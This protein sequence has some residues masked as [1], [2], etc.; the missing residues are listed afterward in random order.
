MNGKIDH[1]TQKLSVFR[2]A[3]SALKETVLANLVLIGEIPAPSCDE[4][5]RI[6][7]MMDRFVEDGLENISHDEMGNGVAIIPGTERKSR[8]LLVSNADTIFQDKEDHTVQVSSSHVQGIGLAEN[9]LGLAVMAS[10][11]AILESLGLTF[12]SDVVLLCSVRSH[13]KSNLE[14][15]RFFL[16]NNQLPITSGICLDG[17]SLGRLG[18]HSLGLLRGEITC[19]VPEEYDWTRFG[20]TGAIMALNDVI[21]K[22]SAICMPTRPRTSIM[23]STMSGG[24]SYRKVPTHSCLTFDVY[25]ESDRLVSKLERQINEIVEEVSAGTRSTMDF[26]IISRCHPGGLAFGHPM[27][28]CAREMIRTLGEEPRVLPSST[29]LAVFVENNIPAVNLGLTTGEN[30]NEL[31]EKLAIEPISSGI[32]QLLGMLL[33]IDGGFCNER[34]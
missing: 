15:F 16:K 30:I 3:A 11:P 9:T 34:E 2:E 28:C 19:S 1:I 7:F 29:E 8:I 5:K 17:V 6:R 10:L 24:F 22:M 4:S 20:A 13:G 33:A 21:N 23:F 26:N 32:A 12:K 14:G 31:D 27:A 25:S 18:I